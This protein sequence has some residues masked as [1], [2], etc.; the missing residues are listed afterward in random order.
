MDPAVARRGRATRRAHLRVNGRL[1]QGTTLARQPDVL[2]VAQILAREQPRINEG[3]SARVAPTRE[4][5]TGNDTWPIMVLLSLVVGF[6]LLL[7]CANLANLVLSRATGRRRELAVRSA[8]GASRARVVRQMLTENVIYGLCGGVLG[9]AVA[10]GGLVLMR[11]FAFEPFFQLL[12]ID[13]NVLLF[14]GSLA[15]L[16]PVLFAILPA[17]QSTRG[18][19]GDAMKE[20]GRARRVRRCGA[21]PLR[22]DRGAAQSCRHAAGAGDAARA[23]AGQDRGRA[24]GTR[25][26]KML[27]ARLELPAWRYGTPAAVGEYQA[28]LLA[29]LKANPAIEEAALIDRLPILDGE[30]ATDVSIAGR[31][32]ARPEDRSWAVT[33]AVTEGYFATVGMPMAAGRGFTGQDLP[34]RPRVAIVNKE[35]ARRYWGSPERAL[36]ARLTIAGDTSA[37]PIEV[38]GVTS[39]VLRADRE[40]ANPQIYL[41][42]R[43]QPRQSVSLIVRAADP[44]A[45][46]RPFGAVARHR[47]DAPCTTSP[48][49]AGDRRRPLERRILAALRRVRALGLCWRPVSLRGRSYAPRSASRVWR[50]HRTRRD[51][52]R[53]RDDDAEA[54]GELVAIGWCSV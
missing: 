50:P 4:A 43:Q 47:P 36:G 41:A 31:A 35:M 6:V 49:Q 33:S 29:R 32:A 14:T 15:L 3:W 20:G 26:A 45:V 16:T 22:P 52:V 27:T 19:A 54:D 17:L 21:Q 1:K 44:T 10:E 51:A 42:A 34:D 40:A 9:L 5:M 28:Q 23:G 37:T 53:H 11:A 24:A 12:R 48:V 13:R 39:D 8:L 2:R 38:V 18:D 7:A 30:P 25:H 46:A